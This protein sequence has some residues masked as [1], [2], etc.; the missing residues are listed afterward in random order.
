MNE[1]RVGFGLRLGAFWLDVLFMSIVLSAV[2]LLTGGQMNNNVPEPN[3]YTTLVQFSYYMFVP[4]IWAGY[5]VGKRIVGIRIVKDDGSNVTALTM[6]L[7]YFIGVLIYSFTAGIGV[8]ISA[9]MIV[10]RDDRRAIHDFIAG[11]YVTKNKA[12]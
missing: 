3:L 12:S 7:R 2:F 11:T 1:N 10:F 6:F 9:C 8:I 5:T 4:V